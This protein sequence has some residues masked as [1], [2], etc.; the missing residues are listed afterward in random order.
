MTLPLSMYDVYYFG[1][2]MKTIASQ[3]QWKQ[4]LRDYSIAEEGDDFR[5]RHG[6]EDRGNACIC[7]C[8]MITELGE[9]DVNGSADVTVHPKRNEVLLKIL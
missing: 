5:L 6:H 1:K 8:A 9:Y 7:M 3:G 2:D 4:L